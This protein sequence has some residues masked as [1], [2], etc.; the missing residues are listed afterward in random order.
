M[1]LPKARGRPIAIAGYAAIALLIVLAGVTG[2]SR[3]IILTPLA[4]VMPGYAI[5][6]AALPDTAL[7]RMERTVYSVALS[8]SIASLG[9]V[10]IQLVIG[11]GAVAWVV[12]LSSVTIL[13]ALVAASRSVATETRS[14]ERTAYVSWSSRPILLICLSVAIAAAS[15]ALASSGASKQRSEAHFAGL[16]MLPG[17]ARGTAPQVSVGVENHQGGT[18]TYVLAVT[19]RSQDL[20]RVS[21]RLADGQLWRRQIPIGSKSQP[22]TAVLSFDGRPLHRVHL[23]EA[24]F[25]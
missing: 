24:S 4:L 21:I 10:L 7:T 18:H 15:V 5:T 22:V 9:G 25:R 23:D 3:A 1:A 12:F 20:A 16:W 17:T 14:V 8:V 19:R 2:W 11:L 6:C 13:A